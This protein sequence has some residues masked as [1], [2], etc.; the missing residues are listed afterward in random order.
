M[1]RKRGEEWR[2]VE[3]QQRGEEEDMGRSP[4]FIHIRIDV[5]GQK[6][7]RRI[8]GNGRSTCEADLVWYDL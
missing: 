2:E 3:D 6:E 7:G 1:D 5:N 8:E 4:I